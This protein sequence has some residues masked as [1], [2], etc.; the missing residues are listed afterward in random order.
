MAAQ[1]T[2]LMEEI[3]SADSRNLKRQSES[4]AELGFESCLTDRIPPDANPFETTAVLAGSNSVSA[5]PLAGDLAPDFT[6]RMSVTS[7][8]A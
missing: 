7:R 3:D 5:P 6:R 4:R 8:F 1:V 2:P